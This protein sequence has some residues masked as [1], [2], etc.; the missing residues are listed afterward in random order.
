VGAAAALTAAAAPTAA[1]TVC[2]SP[3]T[4]PPAGPEP[5]IAVL[6]PCAHAFHYPCI[7]PWL[8]R[9]PPAHAHSAPCPLCRRPPAALLYDVPRAGDA[10]TRRP[11]VPDRQDVA[12]ARRA[13][14][15]RTPR[16]RVLRRIAR[17]A[18]AA[19]AAFA[20]ATSQDA[21]LDAP[22][23]PPPAPPPPPSPPPLPPP[24]ASRQAVLPAPQALALRPAPAASAAPGAGEKMPRDRAAVAAASTSSALAR[25]CLHDAR[26]PRARCAP[27]GA[28][29]PPSASAAK[30]ARLDP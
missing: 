3:L 2:L 6:L 7:T 17:A 23:E 5:D 26:G 9:P 24:M 22:Q 19:A 20:A 13:S 15:A 29:E 4:P 28:A 16:E 12:S 1:C 11:L 21:P 18:T 27:P 8:A 10:Y 25:T 30:R 14:R